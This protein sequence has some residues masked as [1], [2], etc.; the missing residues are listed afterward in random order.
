MMES[1][2]GIS[3]E[4]KGHRYKVDGN[5]LP[6][7]STIIEPI[8]NAEYNGIPEDVMQTAARRGTI[9]HEAVETY[10]LY[11]FRDVP[12]EI[13]GYF[14]AFVAWKEAR[15]PEILASEY[16]VY[17]KAMRYCGTIDLIYKVDGKLVMA[18]VKT[19]AAIMRPL[20]SLQLEGYDRALYSHD[21]KVSEKRVIHLRPDGTFDDSFVTK[22]QES[23]AWQVFGSLLTIHNYISAMKNGRV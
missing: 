21:I 12:L 2:P 13:C 18:D 23:K 6:S 19:T 10:I 17:H 9:I 14:D 5:Y 15:K 22:G 11:G 16:R 1:L 3:F 8:R 4:E 7:V 20:V